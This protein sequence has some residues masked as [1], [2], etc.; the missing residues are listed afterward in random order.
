MKRKG[1]MIIFG[2]LLLC[3]AGCKKGPES[4]VWDGDLLV[5]YLDKNETGLKE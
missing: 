3:L 4:T 2:I 1:F 5:Y